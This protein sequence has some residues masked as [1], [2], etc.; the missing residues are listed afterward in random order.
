[1]NGRGRRAVGLWP[2]GESADAVVDAL[3]QSECSQTTPE[4]KTMIRRAAGAIGS[5]SRDIMVEVV[6]PVVSR[7]SGLG[8]DRLDSRP[9]V[10]VVR[11]IAFAASSE[12][13][14]SR[15]WDSRVAEGELVPRL[16]LVR[17]GD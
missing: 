15:I 13:R 17:D 3:R 11:P 9:A 12:V 10:E 4:E 8:W 14:H 1:V 6:A 2:L 7:Q 5:V 16:V